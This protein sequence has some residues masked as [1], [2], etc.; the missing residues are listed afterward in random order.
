MRI[1]I[2]FLRDICYNYPRKWG[3]SPWKERKETVMKKDDWESPVRDVLDDYVELSDDEGNKATFEL[4]DVVDYQ[5]MEFAVLFPCDEP[6]A[7]SVVIMQ[8][9]ESGEGSYY[10]EVV[11]DAVLDAVFARFRELNRDSYNFID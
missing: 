1:R 9:I 11:D 4:L 6:D 8:Y 2:A 5:G 10:A 7:D 3:I